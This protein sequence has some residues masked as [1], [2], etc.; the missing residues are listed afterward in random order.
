VLVTAPPYPTGT[1]YADAQWDDYNMKLVVVGPILE[2]REVSYAHALMFHGFFPSRKTDKDP[3]AVVRNV[4]GMPDIFS[5]M[6]ACGTLAVSEAV[7]EKLKGFPGAGFQE[8]TFT[9][10]VDVS[11]EVGKPIQIPPA[12]F[13]YDALGGGISPAKFFAALPRATP[14]RRR[15]AGRYYFFWAPQADVEKDRY[16]GVKPV[17]FDF[18]QASWPAAD[19]PM[20]HED[21]PLCIQMMKDFPAV[22]SN[23]YMFFT[24][25]AFRAVEPHLDMRV[26]IRGELD[27]GR[28]TSRCT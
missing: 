1:A 7:R 10:L 18:A 26:F 4:H 9:R 25:E 8:L 5:P 6:I 23:K 19:V 20:A 12:A 21:H 14:G 16:R 28:R 22:Y 15:Q 13:E 27:L 3:Y 11:W 17:S 24:E 2:S